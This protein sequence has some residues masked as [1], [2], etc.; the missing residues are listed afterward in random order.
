M[1]EVFNEVTELSRSFCKNC[2]AP[3][4]ESGVIVDDSFANAIPGSVLTTTVMNGESKTREVLC[5]KC[6]VKVASF[7]V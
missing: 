2:G 1:K 4:F 7:P 5:A 3:L 6:G